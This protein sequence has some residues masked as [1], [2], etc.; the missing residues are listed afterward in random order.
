MQEQLSGLTP[1]E[2]KSIDNRSIDEATWIQLR[3]ALRAEIILKFGIPPLILLEQR[4][5]ARLH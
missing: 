4:K 5:R 3:N 1:L 2:L